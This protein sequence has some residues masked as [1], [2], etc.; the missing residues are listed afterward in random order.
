M[1]QRPV[2]LDTNIYISYLLTVEPSG[3]FVEL[4][5]AA[6]EGVFVPVTPREQLVEFTNA[7]HSKPFL[8][9]R[10]S[11]QSLTL[12]IDHLMAIAI[13]P[14]PLI[15]DVLRIFRDPRDDYLYAYAVR[16]GFDIIVSGDRGVLAERNQFEVP[17]LLTPGEFRARVS[18]WN[19]DQL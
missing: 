9:N 11:D 6:F 5:Q 18:L 15:G 3:V 16:D 12:F 2:I 10:I 1:T 13:I 4:L 7:V 19:T 17:E 8:R 14:D